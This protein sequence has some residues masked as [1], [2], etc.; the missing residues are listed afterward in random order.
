MKILIESGCV[1][2]CVDKFGKSAFH[3]AAAHGFIDIVKVLI[4]RGARPDQPD[5][6][7][8]TALIF[9][10]RYIHLFLILYSFL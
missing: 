1:V 5:I 8:N 6:N 2:E 10:V 3:F 4:E 7:G 9:A